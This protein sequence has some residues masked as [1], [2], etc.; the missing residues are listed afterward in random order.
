MSKYHDR[1]RCEAA[2][3]E[4]DG[5][6]IGETVLEISSAAFDKN[7]TY[8]DHLK[9]SFDLQCA[10]YLESMYERAGVISGGGKS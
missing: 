10:A 6:A 8:L 9:T 2:G 4:Y 1:S 3:L 5:R 7:I